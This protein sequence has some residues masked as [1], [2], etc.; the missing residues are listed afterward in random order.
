MKVLT[1]VIIPFFLQHPL[2]TL[3]GVQ[4][5]TWCQIVNI[6]STKSHVGKTLVARDNLLLVA[7]LMRELNSSTFS[8]GGLGRPRP[9]VGRTQKR[10]NDLLLLFSG[11][12][13]VPTQA[14]NRLS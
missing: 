11:W 2:L 13:L 3:K 4:F 1:S 7:R 14:Q 9:K 5:D 8:A 6:L 10:L 12:S